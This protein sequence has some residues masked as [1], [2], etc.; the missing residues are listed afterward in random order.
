[1]NT[2]IQTLITLPKKA[3]LDSSES[4][5]PPNTMGG[6]PPIYHKYKKKTKGNLIILVDQVSDPQ[7]VGSIIRSSF[8]IVL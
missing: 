7:N 8:F 3:E 1:M 5:T 4:Q 2:L 6:N